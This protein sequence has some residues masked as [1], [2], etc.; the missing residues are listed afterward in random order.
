MGVESVDDLVGGGVAEVGVDGAG[1][2][3]AGVWASGREDVGGDGVAADAHGATFIT[4]EDSATAGFDD[5]AIGQAGGDDGAGS[6]DNDGIAVRGSGDGG[7]EIGAG[8]DVGGGD[9]V[10]EITDGG[11]AVLGGEETGEAGADGFRRGCTFEGGAETGDDDVG[12]LGGE[13]GGAAF[14]FEDDAPVEVGRTRSDRGATTVQS[15]C[16]RLCCA[17]G[18]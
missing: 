14:A 8:F 5:G 2:V 10:A 13:I 1:E 12:G 15:N 11:F 17:H 18:N 7:V 6:G 3:R 16:V 9:D 4:E